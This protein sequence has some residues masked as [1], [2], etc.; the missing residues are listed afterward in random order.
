MVLRW[1]SQ[2]DERRSANIIYVIYV[3]SRI[4]YLI[5]GLSSIDL[6]WHFQMTKNLSSLSGFNTIWWFWFDDSVVAY[7]F[8]ATLYALVATALLLLLRLLNGAD[9][10]KQR[11]HS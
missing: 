7:R 5:P 8:W 4:E 11:L 1:N 3:R 6:Y 9:K 2:L 10:T